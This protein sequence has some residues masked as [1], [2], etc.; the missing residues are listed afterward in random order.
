M[1]LPLALHICAVTDC[2]KPVNSRGWCGGHYARWF[3]YGDP[4]YQPRDPARAIA[5]NSVQNGECILWT[6]SVDGSGYGRI[7]ANNRTYPVHRLVFI[8]NNGPISD[9]MLVDHICRNRRCI[10]LDHLR[11]ATLDQNNHNRSGANKNSSTGHRNIYVR[12]GRYSVQIQCNKKAYYGGTFDDID[13]AI[14]SAARLRSTLFGEFAG[15]G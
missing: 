8:M 10:R 12:N 15:V 3:R 11:L 7:R 5:M 6:A 13:A 1:S 4:T 2:K 14:H 9:Q